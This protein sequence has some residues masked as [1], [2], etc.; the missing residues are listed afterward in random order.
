[1]TAEAMRQ[2]I[3]AVIACAAQWFN[4]EDVQETPPSEIVCPNTW[5]EAFRLLRA[6]PSLLE[7]CKGLV[8]A[9]ERADNHS[10]YQLA[11]A[12][13]GRDVIA[14]AEPQEIRKV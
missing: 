13:Q 10:A 2:N 3:E 9:I 14:I 7:A 6:A 5:P 11:M 12:A 8:D 1:M 4:A